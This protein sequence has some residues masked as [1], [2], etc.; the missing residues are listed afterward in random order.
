MNDPLVSV[1]VITYNSAATVIETLDSIKYQT[2]RNLELIV[3]DD[4]STDNT[5]DICRHWLAVN[6]SR[7][8]RVVFLEVPNNT[9]VAANLNRAEDACQGQ[10]VKGI[11]GDDLLCPDAIDQYMGYVDSHP[12][13]SFMFAHVKAF[14]V[15]EQRCRMYDE[16]VFDYDFLKQPSKEQIRRLE[17]ENNYIPAASF[18]Y[19]L[20][21]YRNLGIRNDERIPLL[22]DHPK[23]INMLKKGARFDLIEDVTVEYRLTEGSLSTSSIRSAKFIQSVALFY[24][25]YQFKPQYKSTKSFYQIHKLIAAHHLTDNNIFWNSLW[26]IYTMRRRVLGKPAPVFFY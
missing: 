9:G 18:F 13:A 21:S 19:K 23:W 17:I 22:E 10:W 12:D 1:T 24:I 8:V 3:S 5:V 15:D 20:S 14:G 25:L 2:Y 7:F 6:E 4:G 11:S 16:S 26:R